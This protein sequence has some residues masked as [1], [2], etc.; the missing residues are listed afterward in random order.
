MFHLQVVY[1]ESGKRYLVPFEIIEK[2]VDEETIAKIKAEIL[3]E[4]QRIA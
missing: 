4:I 1:D 2:Y 3:K